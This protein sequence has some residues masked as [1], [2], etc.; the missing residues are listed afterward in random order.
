M[1]GT[2]KM[3]GWKKFLLMQK[4]QLDE[5]RHAKDKLKKRL[6]KHKEN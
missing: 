5:K 2:W 6:W 1:S 3:N 4:I